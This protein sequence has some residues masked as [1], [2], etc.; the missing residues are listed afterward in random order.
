[1]KPL[2]DY[3]RQNYEKAFIEQVVN[4]YRDKGYAVKTEVK[5]GNYR[6]DIAATKD[7]ET[8]YVEVKTRSEGPDAKRRIKEMANY[9][10][11][12]PNAKFLVMISRYQEPPKIEFDEIDAILYEYFTH[13]LPSDLD[14]LSTHTRVENVHSVTIS[15]VKIQN[16]ELLIYCTGM[17]SVTLQFGSDFDQEPGD[18][19]MNMDFPFKFKGTIDYNE[20]YSVSGCDDLEIDT[21]AFYK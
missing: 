4:D 16:G 8:I 9:F 3:L 15:E 11:T 10:K 2:K 5:V 7:D 14:A 6:V 13:E 19:P 17:V 12:I 21:D 20:S 18:E 1:M